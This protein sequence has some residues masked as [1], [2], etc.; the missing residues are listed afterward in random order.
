MRTIFATL[1][2]KYIHNSL[3]LPCLAAYC[4]DACGEVQIREFTVHEPREAVLALLLDLAPD[5]VVL[6]TYI[7]NRR[8]TLELVDALGVARPGLRLVLG[9]PEVS[10]ET[11]E[12][13]ARHPS[14]T[15]LVRGEGELP[16]RALLAAWQAGDQPTNVPRLALRTADGIDEG[17]DGP[18][19]MELDGIPSPFRNG[20]VDPGRGF[21]YYETSRGCP[22]RC[23]FC[24]SA[25][26][27]PVRSYSMD[28]IRADLG[29]L[30][31]RRVS[32]VKLVDRTFNYDPQRSRDILAFILAHNRESHFH[33]EIAAHL[34]DDRT[35]DLLDEIPAGM[36]QFE[37]GVQSTLET[38]L[39]A[40]DRRTSL[41]RLETAVRRLRERNRIRLHLDLVAGLPGEDYPS[42]LSSIDRVAALRPHHLQIEPVKLLPGSL[43]RDQA[44]RH[45]IRFDPNPPY[46]IL[47][48]AD[49]D[50][51]DLRRIQE[52][53][54]LLDLSLNAGC[55]PT[56]LAGLADQ[57]GSL[58]RG[59]ERLA[60]FWRREELFRFAQGRREIFEQ[61]AAFIRTG[62][63]GPDQQQLIDALAYDYARCERV[64]LNRVPDFF[65]TA[66]RPQERDWVR[67][68]VRRRAEQ[69]KGEPIKLQYFAAV[70]NHLPGTAGRSVRL[71][72]YLTR[73]GEGMSVEEQAFCAPCRTEQ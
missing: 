55:L 54:R 30:M 21:V 48:S 36:F 60:A 31:A 3:A 26:D 37:I 49:L 50:F 70:F 64:V 42:F 11:A 71:F 61:I 24:L 25:E 34:L 62:H 27:Q 53:S 5:V 58:A 6:S 28:R 7:W 22:F 46:T 33:F 9:G 59:L 19:L 12:L 2:S 15:A 39:S 45:G 17:P 56:F 13:F 8:A 14:L 38:A 69:V 67:A 35:L 40:V 73:T 1:H 68:A 43:L 44:E 57:Y 29:W 32:K 47:T 52:I 51:E 10:Y 66:L 20:L 18:P 72:C 63:A 16:L 23:S 41:E 4:G 65:D